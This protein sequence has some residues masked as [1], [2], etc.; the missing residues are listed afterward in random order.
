MEDAADLDP[1]IS[2]LVTPYPVEDLLVRFNSRFESVVDAEDQA[3]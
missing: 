2:G 1:F 3:C